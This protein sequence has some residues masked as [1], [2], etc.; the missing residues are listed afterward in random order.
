MLLAMGGVILVQAALTWVQIELPDAAGDEVGAA[1]VEPFFLA[2]SVAADRVLCPASRRRNRDA[3]RDQR[4][5]RIAALRPARGGDAGVFHGEIYL[6]LLL[7]LQN[8]V[9]TVVGV[10]VAAAECRLLVAVSRARKDGNLRVLQESGKLSGVTIGGLRGIETLKASGAEDS[11]FTRWAG[12][13]A[14]AL[15]VKQELATFDQILLSVPALL[16]ALNTTAILVIGGLRVMDGH[17]TI[18]TLVAFQTLMG[19]FLAPV[20]TL[21]SLG[22][23]L[24]QTEGDVGRLDDVLRTGSAPHL[25]DENADP[26]LVERPPAVGAD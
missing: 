3:G 4:P 9:L 13:H 16:L 26:A 22:G 23:A 1:G 17:L 10:T 7:R 20:A 12:H 6:I 18:G 24:Q 25:T 8:W 2:R 19:S 5:G 15:V 11:F 21:V 14:K